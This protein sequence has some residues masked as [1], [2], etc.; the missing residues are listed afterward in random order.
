MSWHYLQGS[1]DRSSQAN[2][3][4]GAPDAL[5]KLIPT[6]GKYSCSDNV[7]GSCHASLSGP[8]S[9]HLTLSPG[10]AQL[11]LSQQAGP[12]QTSAG[13]APGKGLLAKSQAFGRK[14]SE[15]VGYF[16]P[17]TYSWKIRQ[18]S[19]FEGLTECSVTFTQAGIMLHGQL[20]Q[21][22][23]LVPRTSDKEFGFW[24]TPVATDGNHESAV[25]FMKRRAEWKKKN[26]RL[27]IL[28]RHACQM[29]HMY[30]T[31]VAT[32]YKTAG[33]P[34]QR[35]GS[36]VDPAKGIVKTGGKLNPDLAAWLMGFPEE[37][38]KSEGSAMPGFPRWLHLHFCTCKEG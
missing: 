29:P 25:T 27:G 11:T 10:Q 4:D 37:W 20:F 6:A 28:L 17:G 22:P 24:P 30:P 35:R 8:M 18:A 15:Y 19:L 21:L 36:I 26:V 7:T 31:P 14:L 38:H 2:C 3:L 32:D 5:L 23:T 16:S 34:G 1:E 12:A 9:G 33:K 13:L